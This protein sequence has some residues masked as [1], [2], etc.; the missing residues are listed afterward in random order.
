MKMTNTGTFAAVTSFPARTSSFEMRTSQPLLLHE[1]TTCV[2]WA[3]RSSPRVCSPVIVDWTTFC[4]W[5]GKRQWPTRRDSMLFLLRFNSVNV[6]PCFV[7]LVLVWSIDDVPGHSFFCRDTSLNL[8][9]TTVKFVRHGYCGLNC[10][11]TTSEVLL[12][13]LTS[14]LSK[15]NGTTLCRES[16]RSCE[17]YYYHWDCVFVFT[18]ALHL[19]WVSQTTDGFGGVSNDTHLRAS[20]ARAS[21]G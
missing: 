17:F 15:R 9:G 1:R 3:A 20:C 5:R 7:L 4:R 13:Y 21:Y 12:D 8:P 11:K 16:R 2:V 19:S 14:G 18:C 10:A 6:M